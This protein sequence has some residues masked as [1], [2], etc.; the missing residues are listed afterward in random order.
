MDKKKEVDLKE[1]IKGSEWSDPLYRD[2]FLE[3][4][5]KYKAES[6]RQHLI[7]AI[8]SIY[9]EKYP[10]EMRKFNS[11]MKKIKETR[12]N[13]FSANKKEDQRLLFKFPES[14]W[15][16]LTLVVTDPPFLQ[17]SNPPKKEELE[18]IRWIMK[19]FSEFAMA[20]KF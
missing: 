6:P 8:I 9:I 14:L 4:A 18:E 10:A 1:F 20:D 19:E 16:R 7:R 11:E 2:I 5:T 12:S 15:A 13:E 17:Q 3:L